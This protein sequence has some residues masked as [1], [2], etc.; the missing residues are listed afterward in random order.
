[1]MMIGQVQ[2]Y[3][4]NTILYFILINVLIDY[5]KIMICMENSVYP[6]QKPADLDL[7]CLQESLYLASSSFRKSKLCKD[8]KICSFGQVNFLWTSTLWSF[9]VPGQVEKFTFPHPWCDIDIM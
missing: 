2:M 5:Y 7:H 6:D 1:M 9:N 3:K 4:V 8:R